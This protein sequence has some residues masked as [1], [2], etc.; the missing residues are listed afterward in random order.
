[1]AQFGQAPLIADEARLPRPFLPGCRVEAL[2]VDFQPKPLGDR[3]QGG[4]VAVAPLPAV[5]Q[6]NRFG[7]RQADRP[8]DVR[9]RGE[10]LRI[11]V[12]VDG[13]A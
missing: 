9:R 5:Q 12:G 2:E 8:R 10:A 4:H 1:L 11:E 3:T 7:S 6:P 13:L